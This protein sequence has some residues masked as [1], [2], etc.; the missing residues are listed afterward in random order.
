MCKV[1]EIFR[2]IDFIDLR[3]FFIE[4]QFFVL[5]CFRFMGL[6]AFW[7]YFLEI[8][9]RQN[10]IFGIEKD[11]FE[12]G[13][14]EMFC[15]CKERGNGIFSCVVEMIF[16]DFLRLL[17][18]FFLGYLFMFIYILECDQFIVQ[19]EFRNF[20]LCLVKGSVLGGKYRERIGGRFQF[21]RVELGDLL[22]VVRV[23]KSLW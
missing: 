10:Y 20:V 13:F 22:I 9:R 23:V 7:I 15:F 19:I 1:L 4:Y 14:F 18:F 3:F 11:F 5:Y 16:L 17:I 12:K 21:V 2:N 6:F 8:F